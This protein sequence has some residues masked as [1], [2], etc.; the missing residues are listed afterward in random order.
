VK[1]A[2]RFVAE[3]HGLEVVEARVPWPLPGPEAVARVYG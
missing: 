3:R 2:A 1:N